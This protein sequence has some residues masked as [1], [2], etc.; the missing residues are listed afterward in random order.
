MKISIPPQK[1]GSFNDTSSE[2]LFTTEK[3]AKLFFRL[4][5]QRLLSIHEWHK[6]AGEE[7][8]EFA[9]V[10]KGGQVVKRLPTIGDYLRISI[11]GPT[12]QSGDG[13]D[14]VKV[15][16]IQEEDTLH[17]E[18]IYIK[19]RPSSSPMNDKPVIAHFFDDAATSNFIVKREGTK[20]SAEVH[21]RNEKPNVEDLNLIL[22]ALFF[23]FLKGIF[24]IS[25]SLLLII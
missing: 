3:Q 9:L 21:G 24:I 13:Y 10:N 17:E 12:N 16:D 15:E 8:A 5:R 23:T 2:R 7:K 20:I 18:F 25:N 6:I 4:V 14:W 22:N 11:P 1:K 19:V